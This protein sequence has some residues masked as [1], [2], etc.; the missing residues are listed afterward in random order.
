MAPTPWRTRR[1]LF[2]RADPVLPLRFLADESRGFAIVR[3]L[4]DAG[5]D[6][7]AVSEHTRQ[8]RDE[9]LIAQAYEAQRS[10]AP[11]S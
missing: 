1:F 11:L 4:R 5:H 6:V 2:R 10:M 9:K 7:V 3:A 8:S